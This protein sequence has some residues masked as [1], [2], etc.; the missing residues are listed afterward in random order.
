MIRILSVYYQRIVSHELEPLT[1]MTACLALQS[2]Q[3]PKQEWLPP[4][5]L[6]LCAPHQSSYVPAL[7]CNN[8]SDLSKNSFSGSI[9]ATISQLSNLVSL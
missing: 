5:L 3:R 6:P 2:L 1:W 9:P 7:P 4:F 8:C